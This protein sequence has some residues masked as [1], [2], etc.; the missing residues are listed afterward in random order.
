M[1]N[2]SQVPKTAEYRDNYDRVFGHKE[3]AEEP[4]R[5]GQSKKSAALGVCTKA[6]KKKGERND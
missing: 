1:F 2:Y 6:L 3:P 4:K 5:K